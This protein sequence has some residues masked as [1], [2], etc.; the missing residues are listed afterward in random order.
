MNKAKIIGLSLIVAAIV[1]SIIIQSNIYLGWNMGWRLHVTQ[2][3]LA[4]GNYVTNF[5]D[6]NPPFLIYEYIPAVLLA[7]WTGLSAVASLRITVYLFAILSLA[8]CHRIIQETFPIKDNA[9]KDS[10]LVG[11]AIIFFLAPNTAFSQREHLILLFISPY[12]LYATLLAR[13]KAPSKQ[14]AIITGCFAAIGF[15]T[16]LSFLGVFLLTEIFLMIK[17]RRWK[18]CLRIDT[19]IVLTV[20]AAYISSIFIWTPNYIHIIFPLVISLFTKTFHDPL[21]IILLNYT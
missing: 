19:G 15:C 14:L 3:F 8:L 4:G 13:G 18:T 16:D 20:L 11:L 21:K 10:I 9:F 2:Q 1:V 17:H 5:M 6:I 12:L 7:K